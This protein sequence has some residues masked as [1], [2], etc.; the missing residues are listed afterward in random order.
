MRYKQLWQKAQYRNYLTA[1]T[2]I[3]LCGSFKGST[4]PLLDGKYYM[5]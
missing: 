4:F 2:F 1:P 3:K 5:P